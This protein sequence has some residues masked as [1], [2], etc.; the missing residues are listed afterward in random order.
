[1][2]IF[3]TARCWQLNSGALWSALEW[4]GHSNDCSLLDLE[5][6]FRDHGE[7]FALVGFITRVEGASP[8]GN[9]SN[10]EF[11]HGKILKFIASEMAGNASKVQR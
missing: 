2:Y 3:H 10:L 8:Y 6:V 5:Y 11:S 7:Y 4:H 9:G 1:M